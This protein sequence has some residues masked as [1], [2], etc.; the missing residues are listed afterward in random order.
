MNKFRIKING[1]F[2]VSPKFTV[3]QKYAEDYKNGY[4]EGI[5]SAKIEIEQV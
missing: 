2:L 1:E 4:L 5:P 3:E